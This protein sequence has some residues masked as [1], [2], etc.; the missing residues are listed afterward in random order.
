M[1]ERIGGGLSPQV[2][3]AVDGELAG[4]RER[5]A[6]GEALFEGGWRARLAELDQLPLVE[7][8]IAQVVAPEQDPDDELRLERQPEALQHLEFLPQS[9]GDLPQ[10]R[11]RGP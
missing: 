8:D 3:D 1:M 5:V 11:R 6:A 7:L 4:H 2:A 9:V 10:V